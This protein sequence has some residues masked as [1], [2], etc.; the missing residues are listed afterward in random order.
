MTVGTDR[1]HM[2]TPLIVDG[3]R[4]AVARV[5]ALP[6]SY[7]LSPSEM[8]VLYVLAA[9]S[10]DGETSAP[11]WDNL[12]A[13][14][15]M[16]RSSVTTIVQRLMASN[17][18]RPALLSADSVGGRRRVV[19]R[20]LLPELSGGAGWLNGPA[21]PDG[22]AGERSRNR[23]ANRP[24]NRPAGP[25]APLPSPTTRPP[26]S[27]SRPRRS[28]QAV[29]DGNADYWANGGSFYGPAPPLPV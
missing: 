19:F 26:K 8:V 20:L 27:P 4:P 6:S 15:H 21:G 3:D 14:S 5:A 25:D 18:H 13:W 9:D 11:G 10:F 17:E 29:A 22:S 16:F 7:R 28:R 24:G 23:P 1:A 2:D 12:A